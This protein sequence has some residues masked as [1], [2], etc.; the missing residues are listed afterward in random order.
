M[1]VSFAHDDLCL[2]RTAKNLAYNELQ[3]IVDQT[4]AVKDQFLAWLLAA[5]GQVSGLTEP[6]FEFQSGKNSGL[7]EEFT[8]CSSQYLG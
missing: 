1:N 6:L 3:R 4:C 7:S 2:M 5:Q 8:I